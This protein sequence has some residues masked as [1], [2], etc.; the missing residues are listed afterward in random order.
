MLV[1]GLTGGIGSGKSLVASLFAEHHVPIIDTD[2]ISRT[3]T[4]PKMPAFLSIVKHFGKGILQADGTLDRTQ[5]SRI[6]FSDTEQRLW[7]E[8]LL[9]PLI[10]DEMEK[11]INAL[12]APYCIAIIP[13]LFEVEFYSII[14]R[15]LVVDTPELL[16]IE[17]VMS[18]DRVPRSHVEAILKSQAKRQ[19]R[20]ARA[21]DVILNDG[22]VS[23]LIPQV[24]KLHEMYL[25][26]GRNGSL[27][28]R[29]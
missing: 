23:E 15:I 28:S 29:G 10:Q 4:Q 9:H 26:L 17:R 19:D 22:Q 5:L 3:L 2:V 13:L 14:N 20:V 12:S 8:H 6:I 16:Q 1:V 24:E 25:G 27:T 11:Q 18:R 7:L 21:Q